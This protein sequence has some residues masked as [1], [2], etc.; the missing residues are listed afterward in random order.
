MP[1]VLQ[2]SFRDPVAQHTRQTSK[3]KHLISNSC[4]YDVC[5]YFGQGYRSSPQHRVE[6]LTHKGTFDS[7]ISS[8]RLGHQ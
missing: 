7:K 8:D 6:R 2:H 1:K 4:H 3:N 5:A